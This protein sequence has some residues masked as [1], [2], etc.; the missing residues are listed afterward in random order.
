MSIVK[1]SDVAASCLNADLGRRFVELLFSA[2][3]SN[4]SLRMDLASVWLSR[5]M[6]A[7]NQSLTPGPFKLNELSLVEM[8]YT[9]LMSPPRLQIISYETGQNNERRVRIC[10]LSNISVHQPDVFYIDLNTTEHLELV[11]ICA[12][13]AARWKLFFGTNEPYTS[14]LSGSVWLREFVCDKSIDD[15]FDRRAMVELVISNIFIT[16]VYNK[17]FDHAVMFVVRLLNGLYNRLIDKLRESGSLTSMRHPLKAGLE[18]CET[19]NEIV[20]AYSDKKFRLWLSEKLLLYEESL[21]EMK[22]KQQQQHQQQP[23]Q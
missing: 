15:F 23:P 2:I 3:Q 7:V 8:L 16:G 13:M 12:V 22:E 6:S 9:L 21:M 4:F 10:W 14:H 5:Y 18:L 17:V 20:L 11:N 19:I 1:A